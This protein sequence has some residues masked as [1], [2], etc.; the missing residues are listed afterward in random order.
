MAKQPDILLRLA[1][2][3]YKSETTVDAAKEIAA[4]R[5]KCAYLQ[6]ALARTGHPNALQFLAN[7]RAIDD[8]KV[9]DFNQAREVTRHV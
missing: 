1:Q 2:L 4:L 6:S 3:A 7:A 5:Q 9:V 8:H